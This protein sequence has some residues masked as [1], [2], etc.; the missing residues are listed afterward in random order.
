MD[1]FK[2]DKS[3]VAGAALKELQWQQQED[4]RLQVDINKSNSGFQQALDIVGQGMKDNEGEDDATRAKREKNEKTKRIINTV[5]DGL[6]AL[7]NLG[8]AIHGSPVQVYDPMKGS[9]LGVVNATIEK[10]RADREAR[11]E[12]YNAFAMKHADLQN[13]REAAIQALRDKSDARKRQHEADRRQ[14]QLDRWAVEDR[15]KQD[16]AYE[17]NESQ[18]DKKEQREAELHKANLDLIKAQINNLNSGG[19]TGRRSKTGGKGGS[20]NGNAGNGASAKSQLTLRN[21]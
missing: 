18:K 6:A 10:A 9:A 15:E 19:S 4:A 21:Q 13:Q 20:K 3:T 17:Y 16:Y 2:D 5:S 12:R 8:G 11:K 14:L 7:A 1:V